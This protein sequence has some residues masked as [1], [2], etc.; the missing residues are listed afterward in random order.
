MRER[1]SRRAR[2]GRVEHIRRVGPARLVRG[3]RRRMGSSRR[4]LPVEARAG[5]RAASPR[6]P[7]KRRGDGRRLGGRVVVARARRRGGRFSDRETRG[8]R[9]SRSASSDA[10]GTRPGAAGDTRCERRG[11]RGGRGR[12]DRRAFFESQ[13]G[14]F[15]TRPRQGD[16]GPLVLQ[17]GRPAPVGVGRRRDGLRLGLGCGRGRPRRRAVQA[18][19][20][21][22]R[23]R[24]GAHGRRLDERRRVSTAARETRLRETRPPSRRLDRGTLFDPQVDLLRVVGSAGP[25]P[26]HADVRFV[27]RESRPEVRGA[28][29]YRGPERRL[30]LSPSR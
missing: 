25:A 6:G 5:R 7:R 26:A 20:E 12:R 17:R 10:R 3:R 4:G 22:G 8:G 11:A 24:R 29:R 14:R 2:V 30:A 15:G 1:T 28:R 13:A 18:D 9:A 23:A 21:S 16:D 19:H 27:L